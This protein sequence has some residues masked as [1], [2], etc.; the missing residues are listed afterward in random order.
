MTKGKNERTTCTFTSSQRN[1]VAFSYELLKR[2]LHNDDD[3]GLLS[4]SQ[5]NQFYWAIVNKDE[6]FSQR[7]TSPQSSG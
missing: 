1:K 3:D 5:F 7:K 6:Y 2:Y 4:K